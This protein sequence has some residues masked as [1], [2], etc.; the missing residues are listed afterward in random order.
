M[1]L[2]TNKNISKLI[3]TVKNT[4]TNTHKIV[5]RQIID[6][7]IQPDWIMETKMDTALYGN[8]IDF[9]FSKISITL[10]K[11]PGNKKKLSNTPNNYPIAWHQFSLNNVLLL[12]K[13]RFN[14]LSSF[15][16]VGKSIGKN[17]DFHKWLIE[18]LLRSFNTRTHT[19]TRFTLKWQE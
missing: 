6:S 10:L 12:N 4:P 14:E 16:D 3:N 17:N 19:Y 8:W 2:W 1:V 11:R 18:T 15:K 9:F 13:R 5:D 7:Y